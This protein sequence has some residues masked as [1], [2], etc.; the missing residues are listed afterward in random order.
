[1]R[2]TMGA[3]SPRNIALTPSGHLISY[4]EPLHRSPEDQHLFLKEAVEMVMEVSP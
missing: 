2:D 3:K 4:I 1:M